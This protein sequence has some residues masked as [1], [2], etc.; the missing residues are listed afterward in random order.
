QA[1]RIRSQWRAVVP[2]FPAR[3][4]S[5]A[6]AAANP[7]AGNRA[8]CARA[9][10]GACHIAVTRTTRVLSG[11][12]SHSR[13]EKVMS[14]RQLKKACAAA[15]GLWLGAAALG[16]NADATLGQPAPAFSGKGAD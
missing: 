6:G 9:Q 11:S 4:G 16:V 13:K 7:D 3:T 1:R 8:R 14:S 12:A 5:A 10:A 15:L 2:V